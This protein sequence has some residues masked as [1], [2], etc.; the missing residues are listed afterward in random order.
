M[1]G[2]P[3]ALFGGGQSTEKAETRQRV[4]EASL[5]TKTVQRRAS[6]KRKTAGRFQRVRR[7]SGRARRISA[8]TFSGAEKEVH[9]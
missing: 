5:F 1:R 3:G 7:P 8:L 2:L 9:E 6:K 4:D